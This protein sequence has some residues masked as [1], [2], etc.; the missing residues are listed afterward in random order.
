MWPLSFRFN[1]H[2]P[3]G[4]GLAGMRI[5]PFWILLEPSTSEVTTV[6]RYRNLIIIIIIKGDGGDGNNWNYNTCKAPVKS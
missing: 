6:W 4:A 5:S 2:F 3:G 1:G